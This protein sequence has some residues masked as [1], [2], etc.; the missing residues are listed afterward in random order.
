MNFNSNFIKVFSWIKNRFSSWQSTPYLFLLF[1]I[2]WFSAT[3][4]DGAH[5]EI[6]SSL[7]VELL[8][9]FILLASVD[10]IQ[11]AWR[12][13]LENKEEERVKKNR[14]HEAYYRLKIAYELI[15]PY[16]KK[17]Q[18]F[19]RSITTDLFDYS[20]RDPSNFEFRDLIH[21]YQDHPYPDTPANQRAYHQYFA[22]LSRLLDE[23]NRAI[24]NL[25]PAYHFHIIELYKEFSQNNAEAYRLY[26]YFQSI[27]NSDDGAMR[28]FRNQ[29]DKIYNKEISN[30]KDLDSLPHYYKP[31][32]NLYN[33]TIRNNQ[34]LAEQGY[35]IVEKLKAY[36]D[37]ESG[38]LNFEFD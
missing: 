29:M 13:S 32:V 26:N 24:F 6:R 4:W 31:Y 20:T 25:N 1:L 33:L 16:A 30:D 23:V 27:E 28:N 37:N 3:R 17:Y 22:C 14:E 21:F 12:K 19:T 11:T 35:L 5:D 7:I 36:Q 9:A 2:F 34:I 18:D 15:F 8:G 38:L 10:V